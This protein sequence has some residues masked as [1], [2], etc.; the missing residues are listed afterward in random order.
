MENRGA[1]KTRT[2]RCAAQQVF[3]YSNDR[4]ID[5]KHWLLA[6]LP[7]REQSC[8]HARTQPHCRWQPMLMRHHILTLFMHA[9]FDRRW[10]G[11]FHCAAWSSRET[12]EN[13]RDGDRV[14]RS[15]WQF[16]SQIQLKTL[17]TP[18]KGKIST[19]YETQVYSTRYSHIYSM[20]RQNL[21]YPL[22]VTIPNTF[23]FPFFIFWP[24]TIRTS[25]FEHNETWMFCGTISFYHD[26]ALECLFY[27]ITTKWHLINQSLVTD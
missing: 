10:G 22:L 21:T 5:T 27:N 15:D 4:Q 18:K 26:V 25:L 1:L 11:P 14:A 6:I 3:Y 9:K 23:G 16:A 8:E 12:E 7:L 13:I 24:D 19:S 20:H 2:P 17:S